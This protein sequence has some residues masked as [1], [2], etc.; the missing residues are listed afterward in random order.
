MNWFVFGLRILKGKSKVL[1]GRV[2][3]LRRAWSRHGALLSEWWVDGLVRKSKEGSAA[4]TMEVASK[5]RAVKCIVEA[6]FCAFFS[7]RGWIVD[8]RKIVGMSWSCFLYVSA[9]AGRH[10]WSSVFL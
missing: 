10:P 7:F 8:T 5:V 6:A 1:P 9:G 4:A 2:L 3:V